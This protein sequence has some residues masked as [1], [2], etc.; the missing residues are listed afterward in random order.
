M[1]VIPVNE[2]EKA[3]VKELKNYNGYKIKRINLREKIKALDEISSGI[4][5]DD[6]RVDSG[7]RNSV[8]NNMITRID[9]KEE[10]ERTLKITTAN[11]TIIE[12]ALDNLSAEER[13]VLTAFYID[14]IYNPADKMAASLNIS[15]ANTYNIRD[16]ALKK[17]VIMV[18]CNV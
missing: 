8:E 15:R 12:R 18:S 16:V 4:S 2:K 13:Q 11:I 10:L 7:F 1:E 5:Y 9:K 17:L 6:I 14:R 3:A